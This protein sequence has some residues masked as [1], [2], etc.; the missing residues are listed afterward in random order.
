LFGYRAALF[1]LLASAFFFPRPDVAAAA[2]M[3][4]GCRSTHHAI[5]FV[6]HGAA[7]EHL[8]VFGAVLALL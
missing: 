8:Y 6:P 3:S 2:W 7:A 1:H 4:I 5:R